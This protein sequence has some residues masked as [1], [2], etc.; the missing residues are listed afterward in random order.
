[1]CRVGGRGVVH[2]G[3]ASCAECPLESRVGGVSSSHTLQYLSLDVDVIPK[4][5]PLIPA[6]LACLCF[7]LCVLISLLNW[8]AILVA[9]HLRSQH[10]AFEE[11]LGHGPGRRRMRSK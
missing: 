7:I 4:D 6:G 11:W 3:E 10:G 8:P 9:P 1:M 2:S 5:V